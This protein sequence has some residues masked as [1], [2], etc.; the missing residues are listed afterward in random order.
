M[1]IVVD[2]TID[3]RKV[4]EEVKN[5]VPRAGR[6]RLTEKE[7]HIEAKD[8][9]TFTHEEMQAIRQAVITHDGD[10]IKKQRQ[11]LLDELGRLRGIKDTESMSPIERI[12]RLEKLIAGENAI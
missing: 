5:A 7:L 2:K 6:M 4:I 1:I 10:K 11:D 9:A 12:R 3:F 8:D